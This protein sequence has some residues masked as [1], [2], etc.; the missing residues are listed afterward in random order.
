MPLGKDVG[1]NLRELEKDNKKRG[2]AKGQGGKARSR[3]QMLAIALE[4]AQG[5]K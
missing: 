4:A 1:K 2:K 5:K 3:E